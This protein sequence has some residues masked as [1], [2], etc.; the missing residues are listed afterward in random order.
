M[1]LADYV[2]KRGFELEEAENKLVIRWKD[3]RFI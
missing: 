3:T 1:S 2:K